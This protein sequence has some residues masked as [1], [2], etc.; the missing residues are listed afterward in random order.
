M[1]GPLTPTALTE[2]IR[3]EWRRFWV[4]EAS[5]RRG[6][7]CPQRCQWAQYANPASGTQQS[8]FSVLLLKPDPQHQFD[9]DR[10]TQAMEIS[11]AVH[12]PAAFHLSERR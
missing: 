6:P 9:A 7:R 8:C 3:H 10:E 2:K 1:T 5:G 11:E 4:N 12:G